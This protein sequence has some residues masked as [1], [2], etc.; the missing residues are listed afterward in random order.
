M[1]IAIEGADG[2]GKNTTANALSDALRRA[3]RR[4]AL[5]S[6][7]RYEATVAGRALGEML[8]GRIPV[9]ASPRTA[10][11][12]YALD[13]F[14]S[15]PVIADALARHDLVICDR[16]IASNIAYQSAREAADAAD[17]TMAWIE[18]LETATFALPR[19]TRS[20]YLDT[21][22]EIARELIVRKRRRSY[23]DAAFDE[24]E[25]DVALQRSVRERYEAMIA[26]DM[27]GPWQTVRTCVSGEMRSTDDIVTEII[28]ALG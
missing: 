24:Y 3:G 25:A 11:T 23:T 27:L 22:W 12:L 19:P 18:Q 1:L 16:Y 8:A 5:L 6:F 15:A 14:E 20:F 17:S 9:K 10:A 4:T 26:T 7:P 28:A 2:V 13:R 21:P